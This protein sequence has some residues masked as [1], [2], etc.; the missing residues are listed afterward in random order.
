MPSVLSRVGGGDTPL[1]KLACP[2]HLGKSTVA[3]PGRKASRNLFPEEQKNVLLEKKNHLPDLTIV[4]GWAVRR[5]GALLP[6]PITRPFRTARQERSST[7]LA[8]GSLLAWFSTGMSLYHAAVSESA[9]LSFPSPDN[10]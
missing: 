9:Y 1:S 4:A 2:S 7:G 5:G 8:S 6:L 10:S 3:Y